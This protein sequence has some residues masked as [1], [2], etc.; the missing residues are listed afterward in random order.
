M[1]NPTPQTKLTDEHIE[2]LILVIKEYQ[3]TNLMASL[4]WKALEKAED[5]ETKR[6]ILVSAFA[7]SYELL[8][9]MNMAVQSDVKPDD[10]AFTLKEIKRQKYV[11][12]P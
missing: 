10:F 4:I 12:T 3:V 7:Q 8:V 5:I 6:K 1:L 2:R 9:V 11:V